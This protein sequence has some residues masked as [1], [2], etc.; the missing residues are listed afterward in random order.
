MSFDRTAAMGAH[1]IASEVA[2]G[3][4]SALELVRSRC[5]CID[6]HN[7]RLNAMVAPRYEQAMAEAAA[8]D[9]M[10]EAGRSLGPLAGVPVTVKEALDV[11]GLASTGGNSARTNLPA[12]ADCA[13][14]AA[15]RRAGA[16]VLGKSNLSQALIFVESDNPVFGRCNHPER[17]DRSPGGSS[18]GEGALLAIGA[19]TLGLGTDIGGSGR[20]PAAFCGIASLK[21][22]A[23]RL[24]DPQRLSV[25]IGQLAIPSQLV[26]MARRVA[27]VELLL[28]VLNP[29][30][31][32]FMPS[33]AVDVS[34][35]RVGVYEHDG[36]FAASPGV[37][38]VVR[39]AAAALREAGAR[40]VEFRIPDPGEVHSLYY[41]LLSADGTAGLHRLL[42][43]SRRDARVSQL[44]LLGSRSRALRQTLGLL[45]KSLG[46]A[47]LAALVRSL[48]EVSVDEYWQQCE[49]QADYRARFTA[50]MDASEIGALDL[51]IGPVVAT[52]AF[53]HGATAKLGVPGIYTTLYNVLGWPAG[54]VPVS[55]VKEG[56]ESDRPAQRDRAERAA[57]QVEA[58]SAGLPLAVQVA[59]RP[60]HEHQS[61][62]AMAAIERVLATPYAA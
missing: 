46:Q 51:L 2:S 10:Q 38:R 8:I 14:V 37:R 40:V 60:W 62:A 50:T 9:A 22:T 12:T 54:V 45:A 57:A 33:S 16:I 11:A 18:G 53:T 25:S 15:M 17:E 36:L 29:D 47:H 5:E 44:L 28:R 56:E 27:D 42:H 4:L 23:G 3:R 49:R 58:G 24:P 52:P 61:L 21:P 35:L 39:E 6:R 55:R 1:D 19:S 7:A 59:A 20:V 32:T 43:G 13:A 41:S 30:S 31:F 34:Q 48:G 26:P